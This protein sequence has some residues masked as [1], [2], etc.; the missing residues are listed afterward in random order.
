LDGRKTLINVGSVGQPRDN[1]PRACYVLLD[2][3][4]VI[5]RRVEY[6]VDTTCQKIHGIP[7][8]D[9]YLGDRLRQGR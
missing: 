3:D 1:D 7:E 2:D 4:N 9:K 5:Y 6:D 8:L